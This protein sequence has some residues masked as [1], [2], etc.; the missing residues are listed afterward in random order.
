M[1]LTYVIYEK[2]D[3][4]T[5]EKNWHARIKHDKKIVELEALA[6]HM[7]AH[8][9]PYSSGTIYG[10]LTDMV[11][12]IRE[13]NLEGKKVRLPNLAIFAVMVNS[14]GVKNAA[15]FDISK[16]VKRTR[17]SA[18][19]TG[20]FRPS[21][22]AGNVSFAEADDYA[23]PRAAAKGTN[24]EPDPGTDPGTTDDGHEW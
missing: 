16:L 5:K 18:Q 10:I 14:K 15:D 3:P 7:S 8:N 23:S 4:M 24:T 20:T 19:A 9:T 1:A 6:E 22:L 2:Q 13:L 21:E 11:K 12:C 17:L